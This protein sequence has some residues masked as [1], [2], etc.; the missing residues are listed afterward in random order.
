MHIAIYHCYG[1]E[2]NVSAFILIL[3]I[4][5]IICYCTVKHPVCMP[6]CYQR[7]PSTV[8]DPKKIITDINGPHN[9]F[10]TDDKNVYI[11]GFFDRK[12]YRLDL[13]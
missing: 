13:E 9:I 1:Y 2:Q 10:I 12:I 3:S 8:G 7:D 6:I 4:Q 5:N 11:S